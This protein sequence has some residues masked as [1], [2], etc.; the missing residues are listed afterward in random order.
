MSL[1]SLAGIVAF[2]AVLLF[3][4]AWAF[5]R[6]IDN[7]S[8][9]DALWSLSFGLFA[10]PIAALAP[11]D[12]ARR[13]V[14]AGMWLVW[15]LRLGLFLSR[16]IFSHLD[17]EDRRY[18]K[19]R[20]EYGARVAFRFFLFFFYQAVSVVLLLGPVF[21]VSRDSHA[22]FGA[23]EIA[24]IVAWVVGVIGEATADAQMNAFR[25]DPANRGGVCERGLWRYSRHPNYFFECVT[26][27]GYALFA[28]AS[29]GGAWT[30]YA[31][32]ILWTLILFVTGVPMAEKT[33]L[34]TRGEKYRA[35]Q[36]TTSVL[37]PWFK[38][39]AR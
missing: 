1:L 8:I 23:L 29:P 25:A 6:R 9:V 33:S 19:L 7:Y 5:A 2:A 4:A 28:L 35:Y 18:R 16:R 31:P 30:L 36:R 3:S 24:G 10:V 17:E 32:A 37:V 20:E 12:P 38:K 27:L 39:S 26:W 13:A 22:G 11:G 34:R 21:V 14:Y 15:S